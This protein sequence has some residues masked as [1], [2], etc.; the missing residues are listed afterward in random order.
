MRPRSTSRCHDRRAFTLVELLVAITILVILTTL[1]IAAFQRDDGDRL[2]ASSRIVQAYLEGARSRA[3]SS[4]KVRGVRLIASTRDPYVVDSLVYIGSN[5]YDTGFADIAF[6]GGR[7]IV[8]NTTPGKWNRLK[9]PTSADPTGRDLLRVGGRIELPRGARWYSVPPIEEDFN[10]DGVV[11]PGEDFNGNGE[12]DVVLATA[13][14]DIIAIDGHYEPSSFVGGTY[15]P[16]QNRTIGMMP[17]V[18]GAPQFIAAGVEHR[19]ELAPT[20]LPDTEPVT[21]QRGIVIDLDASRV[22]AAWRPG[23]G[24]LPRPAGAPYSATMDILFDPR[25]NPTGTVA[26]S[27][28]IH[29]YI[30]SL[31]DVEM[32]RNLLGGNHPADGGTFAPAIVPA[33]APSVPRFEPYLVNLFTQTGQVTTARVNFIDTD[34]NLIADNP[35]GYAQRGREA[36]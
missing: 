22:P 27:G 9:P 24:A 26:T 31:A 29:L 15:A 4:G 28:L 7:W 34:G 10:G 5:A 33:N 11:D 20:I 6:S 3:I 18:F 12:W 21:L 30:T 13:A 23:A 2:N 25:G 32:T 1:V 35:F 17:P 14:G 8:R 36:Q 16:T 19:L